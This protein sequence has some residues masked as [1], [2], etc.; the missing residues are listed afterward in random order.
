MELRNKDNQ[1]HRIFHLVFLVVVLFWPCFMACWILVSQAGM[2]PR[3]LAAESEVKSLSR[4]QLFV[5]PWTV[6][7]QAPLSMGFSRQ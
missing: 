2:Q 4:V 5:T 6:A 1:S 7:Y 3:P